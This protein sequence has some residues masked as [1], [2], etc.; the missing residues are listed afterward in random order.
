MT[1]LGVPWHLAPRVCGWA[2]LATFA[3]HLPTGSATWRARHPELAPWTEPLA[4]VNVGAD[5]F[6]VIARFAHLYASAHS[7]A[8]RPAP[9]P[10]PVPWAEDRAVR[11]G[12][13]AIPVAEFED[14]YYA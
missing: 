3:K 13:G 4:L 12:S 6:N 1:L 14:W 8:R 10:Y 5:V 2:D 7:K 11:I 9:N